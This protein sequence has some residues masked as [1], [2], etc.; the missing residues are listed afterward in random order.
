MVSSI[1]TN[2]IDDH[3][4]SEDEQNCGLDHLP[5]ILKILVIVPCLCFCCPW[6]P[7]VFLLSGVNG[8]GI[9]GKWFQVFNMIG[10]L[11]ASIE[12]IGM[13][14]QGTNRIAA[15]LSFYS[16]KE[17]NICHS[18]GWYGLSHNNYSDTFLDSLCSRL[19]SVT[20][21]T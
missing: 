6:V 18:A 3:E 15:A 9:K 8:V 2:A 19:S 17:C 1:D 12:A 7:L 16:E 13:L 21:G 5:C 14:T 11:A 4:S 20:R 10:G